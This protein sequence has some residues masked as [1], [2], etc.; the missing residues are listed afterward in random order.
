MAITTGVQKAVLVIEN[1]G[2]AVRRHWVNNLDLLLQSG[3]SDALTVPEFV[4]LRVHRVLL[5]EKV[6]TANNER[7]VRISEISLR[8]PPL[9]LAKRLHHEISATQPNYPHLNVR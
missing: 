3:G 4:A 9:R 6:A 2:Q 5:A 1:W 8:D 7:I